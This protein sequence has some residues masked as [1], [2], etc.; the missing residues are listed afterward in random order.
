[1]PA[2]IFDRILG[3]LAK[4]RSASFDGT[5]QL[6]YTNAAN[7]FNPANSTDLHVA[8]WYRFDEIPAATYI[9]L[10]RAAAGAA[11]TDGW[12]VQL[13]GGTGLVTMGYSN[14][15]T[16]VNFG[17]HTPVVN[18]WYFGSFGW[19]NQASPTLGATIYDVNGSIFSSANAGL[20]FINRPASAMEV[21]EDVSGTR[22]KGR[23]DKLSFW[24]RL[25]GGG[26]AA[27]LW[28]EGNGST[29]KRIVSQGF[30][31]SMVAHYE[32]DE[33]AGRA[34][35]KDKHTNLYHLAATGLVRSGLRAGR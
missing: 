10:V 18:T 14:G 4:D 30:L 22:F 27:A 3:G 24:F 23:I 35:W 28:N 5:A 31:T 13:D 6:G 15:A 19:T 9:A 7:E 8:F 1:M 17:T 2:P 25:P 12:Y 21:A 20:G 11:A 33:K 16:Y 34:V 29:Y 26:E 32:M